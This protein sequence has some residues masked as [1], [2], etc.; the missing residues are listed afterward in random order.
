MCGIAGFLGVG[1]RADL[2]RMTAALA[3]RGPDASGFFSDPAEGLHLG[4][5]RLSIVDLSGGAQPMA[6]PDGSLQVTFNGEIYNHRELRAELQALGCVFQSDHSDT[7]VLLHA[8]R[9][10]GEGMVRRLNG[11]WAFALWDARRRR[12]FL[13]RDRFGKKPLYWFCRSGAFAFASELTALMEHGAAPRSVSVRAMQKFF[14]YALIPAPHSAIDGIWKLPAGHNLVFE[15][16]SSAPRVSR[17]WR[18]EIEPDDALAR[19]SEASLA[20]ELRDILGRAVARRLVADVP[21]GVFLSGGIDS[22]AIA[23]LAAARAGAGNLR[24]FSIGF[25]EASFDESPFARRAAAFLGT[26][27]ESEILDLDKACEFLPRIFAALDEPQGDNSLLPTWLLSGFTRRHVTVALGGDGG[28]ELFAGYDTFRGL[29]KAELYG[30]L[31]PKPVHR[32]IR[33]LVNRLPVSHANLSTDFKLKRGMRGA[34]YPPKLWNPVWLG[35]LEPADIGRFFGEKLSAEDVF[36]EAIEVW[37]SCRQKSLID[38]TLQFY[39][40]IYLQDG[41]LAKVDRASML[42]GLEARSPFLDLEVADFA[43]RLPHDFKLRNGVTKFLLKKALEPLLPADLIYRKKKG[44]GTPVGAWFR[45]GRIAPA[46]PSPFVREML[47]SHRAGR[48]DERLF[49]WCQLCLEGWRAGRAAADR[50]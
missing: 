37:D 39:T 9:E 17:H 14:A 19:R 16:G 4:H 26:R 46:D 48:T 28:D 12:I 42:H 1:G 35:A 13:S 29:A 8:Y 41:I 2:E 45:T 23:A 36:S 50:Q 25:T 20:E 24:T 7:E 30:R 18:F 32:G 11:M 31:V 21:V 47:A 40:E 43:R 44:F 3:H 15:A 38:R 49:L 34:S 5:R 33:A 22:T 6:L 27:H 10:W